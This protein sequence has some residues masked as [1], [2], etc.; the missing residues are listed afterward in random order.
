LFI[1]KKSVFYRYYIFYSSSRKLLTGD[2]LSH[3]LDAFFALFQEGLILRHKWFYHAGL[4]DAWSRKER[5]E[6]EMAG[7]LIEKRAGADIYRKAI[8]AKEAAPQ[9]ST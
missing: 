6:K 1:D 3:F 7:M 8:S 9:K 4:P 5:E 2:F